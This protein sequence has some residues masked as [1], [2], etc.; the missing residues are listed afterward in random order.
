MNDRCHLLVERLLSLGQRHVRIEE[1]VAGG[2]RANHREGLE[3]AALFSE[4]SAKRVN[5]KLR[6]LHLEAV[7][8]LRE[9]RLADSGH[10]LGTGDL[11]GEPADEIGIGAADFGCLLGRVIL[12]KTLF[13][14]LENRTDLDFTG[15][16]FDLEFAFQRRIDAVE[17]Q[18]RLG[19]LPDAPG[20][21][22]VGVEPIVRS[23][24]LEIRLAQKEAGIVPH[25][26]RHVGLFLEERGIVKLVRDYHLAE[27]QPQRGIAAELNR[28][29]EV[30]MNGGGAVIGSDRNEFGAVIARLGDEVK[31]GHLGGYRI[32]APVQDQLGVEHVIG[33]TAKNNLA[34][35]HGRSLMFISNI[36]V[37][38][39]QR[40]IKQERGA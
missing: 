40:R 11:A 23:A 4:V 15:W 8:K 5:Q 31:I 29:P 17:F 20:G 28:D 24:L 37:Q 34:A 26:E 32:A 27:R 36:G 19:H 6:A 25:Q 35:G 39:P 16:G 21:K 9:V 2:V 13:E 12:V 14:Q 1:G 10:A 33:G 18:R 3:V 30:R 38:V 22:V 7:V